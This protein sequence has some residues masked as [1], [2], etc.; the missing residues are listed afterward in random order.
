MGY[1]ANGVFDPTD[2]ELREIEDNPVDISDWDEVTD[3]MYD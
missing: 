2:E 3:D 1:Y